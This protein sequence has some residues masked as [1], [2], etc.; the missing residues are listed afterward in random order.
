MTTRTCLSLL[1]AAALSGCSSFSDSN[2]SGNSGDSNTHPPSSKP[3]P[4]PAPAPAADYG[5]IPDHADRVAEGYG[6]LDFRATSDGKVWIGNESRRYQVVTRRVRRNDKVEVIPE[7]DRVELNDTAIFSDNMEKDDRHVVYFVPASSGGWGPDP[8]ADIPRDAENVISASGTIS[9]R[10]DAA[11]TIY[12]GNDKLHTNI[13]SHRVRATDLVE[14]MPGEDQIK[15]NGKVIY[16]QNLE[17][18]HKHS[19]FIRYGRGENPIPKPPPSQ[20]DKSR[21]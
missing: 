18:K 11:G 16:S 15:V 2:D 17:S 14:V 13:V 12:V 20:P 19:I 8:Y 5:S 7:R 9:W 6:R 1:L 4:A 21:V 10:A 3:A